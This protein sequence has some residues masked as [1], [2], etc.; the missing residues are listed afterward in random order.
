[1]RGNILRKPFPFPE[2]VLLDMDGLLLDTE[3]VAERAFFA[4]CEIYQFSCSKEAY[5][6]L[7]G[8]TSVLRDKLLAS[9]LPKDTDIA[10]FNQNWWEHFQ[11]FL[12]NHVPIKDGAREFLEYMRT[13]K[14]R[15]VVVTSSHTNSAD[16]LL[17]RAKLRSF[18]ELIIGGDQVANVKPAGDIYLKALSLVNIS[19]N[20]CIAFE[21]SDVGVLAAHAAGVPVIQI[22][23]I[24]RPSE[25]CVALGH[26]IFDSFLN[27]RDELGWL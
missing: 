2:A 3:K 8:H 6:Q 27:A 1:M 23:D 11:R 16:D 20:S 5:G 12:D 13:K 19:A 4:S 22:P 26:L 17:T 24:I 14:I 25:K 18:V 7:T 15:I 21:D 9:I 10:A